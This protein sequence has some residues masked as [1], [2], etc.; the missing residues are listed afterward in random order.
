MTIDLSSGMDSP[1]SST[2]VELTLFELSTVVAATDH[3]SPKNKLGRGGF[4]LV[5]KV[6]CLHRC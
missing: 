5:Y 6:V 3:F 4:G 1:N 2:D